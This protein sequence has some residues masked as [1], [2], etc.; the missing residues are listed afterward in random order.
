MRP[1]LKWRAQGKQN[2]HL[3]TQT[4]GGAGLAALRAIRRAD[5][6]GLGGEQRRD[7]GEGACAFEFGSRQKGGL[8]GEGQS[9]D[10]D[11][12]REGSHGGCFLETIVAGKLILSVLLRNN[13]MLG[14]LVLKVVTVPG[15]V[16]FIE[17]RKP[18]P[19]IIL[20]YSS[21][22]IEPPDD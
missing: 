22:H 21:L 9:G 13:Y 16:R 10:K 17:R 1:G 14:I 20:R 11:G 8:N 12:D 3:R 15:D 2:I 19:R 4:G 7:V 18:K 5:T 6:I